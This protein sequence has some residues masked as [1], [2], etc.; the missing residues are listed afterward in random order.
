MPGLNPWK[1]KAKIIIYGFVE[2]VNE[3]QRKPLVY[4]L[5]KGKNFVITKCKND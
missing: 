5:I 2:I 3:S 1:T 4:G